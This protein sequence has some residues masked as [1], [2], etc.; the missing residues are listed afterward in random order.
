MTL[1]GEIEAIVSPETHKEKSAVAN[2]Q[3]LFSLLDELY[4]KLK[5]SVTP[6]RDF[7]FMGDDDFRYGAGVALTYRLSLGLD[8]LGV[9][10]DVVLEYEEFRNRWYDHALTAEE[11]ESDI[12]SA[13]DDELLVTKKFRVVLVDKDGEI[14]ERIFTGY[15]DLENGV[16]TYHDIAPPFNSTQHVIS[17]EQTQI[18]Q[19]Y[20]LDET[21]K[22]IEGRW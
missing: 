11:A 17:L 4:A 3:K 21:Q 19:A 5:D 10:Q 16:D 7:H 18:V 15:R 13:I 14:I 22:I 6:D 12:E 8:E 9:G 1:K 20:V 2:K